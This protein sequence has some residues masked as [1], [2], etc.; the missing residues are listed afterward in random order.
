MCFVVLGL[1]NPQIASNAFTWG[2]AAV[3]PFY[4]LMIVAPRAELVTS[5]NLLKSF[6]HYQAFNAVALV[7][8][9]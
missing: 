8:T 5:L 6:L 2:T 7:L 4:T 9:I 3:L 1:S